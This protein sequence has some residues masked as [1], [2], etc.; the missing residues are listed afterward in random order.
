MN[1]KCR[2]LLYLL[3]M[4][5]TLTNC[6]SVDITF[7]GLF[8]KK[9]EHANPSVEIKNEVKTG[10]ALLNDSGL[11]VS[12]IVTDSLTKPLVNVEVFLLKETKVEYHAVTDSIGSY[13]IQNINPD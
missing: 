13:L 2:L 4:T 12:G 10:P 7:L 8:H 11:S 3:F 9:Y 5:V 1:S 6:K